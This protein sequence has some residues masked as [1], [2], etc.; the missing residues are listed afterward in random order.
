MKCGA[1]KENRRVIRLPYE[2]VLTMEE[3][4]PFPMEEDGTADETEF[5]EMPVG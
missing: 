3:P 5:W 2:C 1:I 4:A